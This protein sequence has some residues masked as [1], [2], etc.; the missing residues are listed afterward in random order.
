M[1]ALYTGVFTRRNFYNIESWLYGTVVVLTEINDINRTAEQEHYI[2][3]QEKVAFKPNKRDLLLL[4]QT[5]NKEG[6]AIQL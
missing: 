2:N 1:I 5:I 6:K 3:T 4:P